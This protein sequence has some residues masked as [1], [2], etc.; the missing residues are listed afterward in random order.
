[1]SQD[2]DMWGNAG[3]RKGC[4]LLMLCITVAS[5]ITVVAVTSASFTKT[6]DIQADLDVATVDHFDIQFVL[7]ELRGQ[8]LGH[9]ETR[10]SVDEIR[11]KR[12]DADTITIR[13]MIIAIDEQLSDHFETRRSVD[14][15]QQKREDF[16]INTIRDLIIDTRNL[17]KDFINATT[18]TLSDI[19]T[20]VTPPPSREEHPPTLVLTT[21]AILDEIQVSPPERRSDEEHEGKG[22]RD[23]HFTNLGTLVADNNGRLVTIEAAV[24][25]PPPPPPSPWIQRSDEERKRDE[26]RIKTRGN[27]PPSLYDLAD[28]TNTMV[29][30]HV[31]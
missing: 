17:L 15:I 9:I 5:V 24:T 14:G 31:D 20:Q 10:R 29:N 25:A 1:M 19:Q 3:T 8:L 4:L 11:Q 12:D 2:E 23:Q 27:G 7:S 16:N 30:N 13:D 18:Q 26:W 28:D 6:E 22:V 21:I